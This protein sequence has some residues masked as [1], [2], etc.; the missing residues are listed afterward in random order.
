MTEKLLLPSRYRVMVDE[1]LQQHVPDVEVWAYGSR[2]GGDAH[3][4]SDLD[5]VLRSPTLDRLGHELHD[6]REAFQE[7]NLPIL[8]QTHD[9][10]DLRESFHREIERDH[11]VLSST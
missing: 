3:E 7:S 10:A 2:V 9:W 1:L 8:V 5:M 4:A 11:V 6:L